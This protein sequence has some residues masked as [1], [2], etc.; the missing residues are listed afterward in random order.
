MHE[1]ARRGFIFGTATVAAYG[2]LIGVRK[3]CNS[4]LAY[5]EVEEGQPGSV[6]IVNFADDGS[7]LGLA[8]APKII[9]P[10]EE[11]KKQLTS[12]Q[13]DVTRRAATEY[14]YSGALFDEHCPG[15]Y[16]CIGCG[17]ALCDSLAKYDSQTGWPSFWQP[18]APENVRE[19]KDVSNG[20]VRAEVKCALCD[21]H[22]GHVFTDGP[23]PTGLRYCVNSAA[24][25]F[26]P[27]KHS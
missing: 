14:A 21:A 12:L 22:L 25:R 19:A 17:N 10:K 7:R 11:W 27:R 8:T 24:L 15:L 9:K 13:Y 18:I 4:A 23:E 6:K 3:L 16:R 20:V 1:I 2:M 5:D 26:V